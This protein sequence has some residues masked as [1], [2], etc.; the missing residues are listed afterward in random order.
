MPFPHLKEGFVRSDKLVFRCKRLHL[1]GQGWFLKKAIHG[2]GLKQN[3]L[4]GEGNSKVQP[5]LGGR[6]AVH[7]RGLWGQW[8]VAGSGTRLILRLR[9]QTVFDLLW[10]LHSR[11]LK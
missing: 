9:D 3:V 2:Y 11:V 1:F 10:C 6:E 8:K 7:L 4:V 5:R